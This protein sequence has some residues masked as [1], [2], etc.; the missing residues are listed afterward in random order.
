MWDIIKRKVERWDSDSWFGLLIWLGISGIMLIFFNFLT[1][2]KMVRCYYLSSVSTS[3]G[4]AYKIRADI[5]Y[6]DDPLA[7]SSGDYKATME[8]F[9]EL[10]QCPP[11][12]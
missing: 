9:K 8:V 10:P 11:E 6:S 4:I 1:A 3:A 12:D 5:D 2:D 7:F